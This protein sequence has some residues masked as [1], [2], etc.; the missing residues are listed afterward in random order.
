MI[1]QHAAKW[2]YRSHDQ[3]GQRAHEARLLH[4]KTE[5]VLEERGLEQH[6]EV[7]VPGAAEV[8]HNDGVDRHRAH[9]FPPRSRLQGWHRGMSRLPER[10]LDVLQLGYADGRMFARVL[11]AQPYP[12]HVPYDSEHPV[13]VERR[14]VAHGIGQKSGERK[15]NHHARIGTGKGQRRQS[16]ALHGRRPETPDTMASWIGNALKEIMFK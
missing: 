8:G 12:E 11:E 7:E 15:S 10:F 16:G 9:H 13:G 4:L 14:L 5:L 1:R 6:Q 2:N 3:V